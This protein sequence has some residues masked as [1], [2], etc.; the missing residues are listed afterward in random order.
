[1]RKTFSASLPVYLLLILVIAMMWPSLLVQAEDA[2]VTEY[3]VQ[4][5]D[6]LYKIA[7]SRLGSGARWSEIYE[8]NR[9]VIKDPSLIYVGQILKLPGSESSADTAPAGVADGSAAQAAT[10]EQKEADKYAQQLCDAAQKVEPDVTTLLKSLESDKAHLEGLENKLKSVDST[11]RKILTNAHDMEVSVE[12]A[13]NTITDALR[14]TFVI[15]DSDYVD[16]T[17][18]I[19]DTLI[20][21]GYTV[22]AFKNYW[23]KK[24]VAYQG[25]NALFKSKDGVIFEL[26]YHT[27]DSYETKGEKTHAYYEIIR[28]ETAT[29]EEKAEAKKKHDALF[30]L[31]PVP[32]GVEDIS[33]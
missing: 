17:R 7:K 23:A 3:S 14:Y 30:E 13:S 25:I 31:I 26:Q 18:R 11:S 16:M 1:M 9:S 15:K 10:D 5:N 28:S 20:A 27:P 33:Y 29:D 8:L 12:E 19:T 6:N 2:P 32:D 21:R 22:H 4:K 24:D